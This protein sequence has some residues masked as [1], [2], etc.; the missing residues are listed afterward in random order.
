MKE[1]ENT[2]QLIWLQG[3]CDFKY[4]LNRS[5]LAEQPFCLLERCVLRNSSTTEKLMMCSSGQILAWGIS[6]VL[7]PT[8]TLWE[9]VPVRTQPGPQQHTPLPALILQRGKMNKDSMGSAVQTQSDASQVGYHHL[10]VPLNQKDSF[11]SSC[12]FSLH[13]WHPPDSAKKPNVEIFPSRFSWSSHL[14]RPQQQVRALRTPRVLTSHGRLHGSLHHADQELQ[15]LGILRQPRGKGG[16]SIRVAS[17]VLQ[18]HALTEVCLQGQRRQ[19]RPSLSHH[20]QAQIITINTAALSNNT[21]ALS[22]CWWATGYTA[23][24]WIFW[25]CWLQSMPPNAAVWSVNP[26]SV[27]PLTVITF[28]VLVR[29]LN[30]SGDQGWSLLVRQSLALGLG[31]ILLLNYL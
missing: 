16:Q 26:T 30:C 12:N 18:G 23:A 1:R 17:Q 19:Q 31:Q 11:C 20:T 9:I 28:S 3:L 10:T 29:P 4:C 27:Y 13:P 7:L 21:T 14:W 6:D 15:A 25:S 8:K 22:S 5:E 2:A 24:F